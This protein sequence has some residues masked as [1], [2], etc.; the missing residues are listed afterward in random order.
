[1]AYYGTVLRP[2]KWQYYGLLRYRTTA[3]YSTVLWHIAVPTVT[4]AYCG[5]VLRRIAVPYYGLLRYHKMAYYGTLLRPITV[6][7]YGL[8][9]YRTI[10]RRTTEP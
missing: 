1:M 6:P 9:Q 7:F 2:I 10:L 8:L 3:Y 5:I 4:T